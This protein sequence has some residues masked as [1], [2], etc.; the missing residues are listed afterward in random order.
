MGETVLR[1]G[2]IEINSFEI[3]ILGIQFES[4]MSLWH[5]RTGLSI[6]RIFR[7][8]FSSTVWL[9]NLFTMGGILFHA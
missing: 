6:F 2:F 9:C 5:V 7:P 4:A 1:P 3:M 8:Q